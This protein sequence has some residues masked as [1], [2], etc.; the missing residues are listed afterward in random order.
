MG[1]R[2]YHGLPGKGRS[3]LGR[4]AA[5]AFGVLVLLLNIL[6]GSLSHHSESTHGLAL[7]EDGS[8]MAICGGGS[9]IFAGEDGVPVTG[10]SG[11][12]RHQQHE[13]NCCVLMHSNA[14]LPPPPSAPAPA[15]LSAVQIMRPGAVQPADAAAI[16]TRRNRDPPSQA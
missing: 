16:P 4:E 15:E 14:V 7:P 11:K 2:S 10:D 13:C 1:L 6:T 3:A 5:A 9:T 12:S 8:K